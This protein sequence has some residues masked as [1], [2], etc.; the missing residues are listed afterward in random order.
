MTVEDAVKTANKMGKVIAELKEDS[1][2]TADLTTSDCGKSDKTI[3]HR[4]GG[5]IRNRSCS[6]VQLEQEYFLL[7]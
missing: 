6:T 2:I 3:L 4:A 7:E 1:E 5:I